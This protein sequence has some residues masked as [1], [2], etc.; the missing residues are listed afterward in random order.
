MDFHRVAEAIREITPNPLTTVE[1]GRVLYE[2]VLRADVHDVLELGFGHGT[3]ACY[4]AAALHEKGAGR[5]TTIDRP[6]AMERKP[7][8]FDSLDRTGLSGFVDPV[9]A[10]KSY[11]WELMKLIQRRTS[12]NRT[13]PCFDFCFIDGAHTWETD[14]LAFF[15][16]DKLLRGGGWILFDDLHWTYESSPT[17]GERADVRAMPE[18]ERTTP[19]LLRVV[20]LLVLQHPSYSDVRIAGRYA[21]AYKEPRE[22]EP[23]RNRDAV[24]FVLQKTAGTD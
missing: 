19:Q 12:A 4:I 13:E 5:I 10:A 7:T 22:D 24:E 6:S 20:G 3:S 9:I 8:V 23:E 14:G 21:W 11:N 1:A 15:L 17:L 18:D 16:V 2:F